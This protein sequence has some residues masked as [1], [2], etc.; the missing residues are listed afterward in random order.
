MG[1][2]RKEDMTEKIES[3]D[4]SKLKFDF[5]LIEK[6]TLDIKKQIGENTIVETDTI[7][8]I[9]RIP[10]RSPNL[11]R[12]MGVQGTP[13]GRIIEIYGPE[14][15]GKSLL[16][17]NIIADFQTEGNHAVYIDAEFS[18][19]PE[20]ATIQ[21]MDCRKGMLTL[22]LPDKGEDAFTIA[23][24]YAKTGQVGIICIDS[25]AACV[26]QAELEGEMTDQQMGAQARLIGKGLRKLTAIL[27]KTGTTLILINQLRMKIGVMF[28]NPET[29]P[30]GNAPK[31]WSSI[32]L[33]VRKMETKDSDN[34]KEDALGIK[35]RVKCVKN[36]TS[37]PFRKCEM[38]F[39]FKDGVDVWGEY[40]DFGVALNLI[41]KKGAW[42]AYGEEKIGQGRD[43]A[44][45]F[46]KENETVFTTIKTKVDEELKG[47]P[48]KKIE[49]PISEV[50]P[51]PVDQEKSLAEAALE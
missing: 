25:L 20:Y 4:T 16:A 22:A 36:K 31:F 44:I 40:V 3:A 42:Y 23:E 34:E 45:K 10:T 6:A 27:G 29:T 17:Q 28:G 13:K 49:L 7:P 2:P 8:R 46:L 5:S 48:T 38:Y 50:A 18:F 26:P 35:S 43:N 15:S 12:L 24:E 41:D 11:G 30:G 19:D 9:A 51:L 47:N 14:S 21:G 32:R 37:V 1:R 33:E 39:S